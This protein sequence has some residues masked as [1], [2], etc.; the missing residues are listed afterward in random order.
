MLKRLGP[1][2]HHRPAPR[3]NQKPNYRRGPNKQQRVLTIVVPPIALRFCTGREALHLVHQLTTNL[4]HLPT[5]VLGRIGHKVLSLENDA[6]WRDDEWINR[7]KI[8]PVTTPAPN[9]A[10]NEE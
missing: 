3:H 8:T 2:C 1:Q 9:A 10:A 4:G 6:Q 5:D 7:P